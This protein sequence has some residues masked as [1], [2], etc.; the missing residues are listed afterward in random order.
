MSLQQNSPLPAED[1]PVQVPSTT[2][3]N[4]M[5]IFGMCINL[6]VAGGL[7]AAAVVLFAVAPNLVL[8]ALPYLL[9]AACPLSMLFMMRGRM[10]MGGEAAQ[11]GAAGQYTCPMHPEV[12]T[13][14]PGRCPRCGMALTPAA[15]PR[16]V[17]E[18]QTTATGGAVT[19]EDQLAELR[20]QLQNLNEQQAALARQIEQMQASDGTPPVREAE[21]VARAAGERATGRS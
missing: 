15:P 10:N 14:Q 16:Q 8:S 5:T 18:A 11:P 13:D 2:N 9:I 3:K 6:R 7:A 19:R 21:A 20:A 4:M 17:Q 1:R 12:R